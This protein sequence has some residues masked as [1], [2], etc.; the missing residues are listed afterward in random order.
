ML[1][2]DQLKENNA[3]TNLVK[4]FSEEKC[5]V[6]DGHDFWLQQGLV[7]LSIFFPPREFQ[8][9]KNAFRYYQN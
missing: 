9:I 8:K 3:Q 7:Q 1:I 6:V 5:K 2:I 4:I